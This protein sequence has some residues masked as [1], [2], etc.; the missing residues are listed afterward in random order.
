MTSDITTDDLGATIVSDI[1]KKTR[2][3]EEALSNM[4]PG[5]TR[6]AL[7]AARD[8][9]TNHGRSQRAHYQCA[10]VLTDLSDAVSALRDASTPDARDAAQALL[11]E[12]HA[13]AITIRDSLDLPPKET[14]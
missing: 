12:A 7:E 2:A 8:V 5:S 6:T 11:E 3:I 10:L 9:L 1:R 13:R 14:K 4:R